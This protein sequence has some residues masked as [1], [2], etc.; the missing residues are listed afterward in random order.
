VVIAWISQGANWPEAADAKPDHTTTG[1][2]TSRRR[3]RCQ[4]QRAS[5]RGKRSATSCSRLEQ[6]RGPPW[7]KSLSMCIRFIST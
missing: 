7:G 5:G 2:G 1:P 6:A 4:V 3:R